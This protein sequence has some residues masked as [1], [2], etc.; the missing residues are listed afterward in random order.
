MAFTRPAAALEEPAQAAVAAMVGRETARSI[1]TARLN[2][3]KQAGTVAGRLGH[4]AESLRSANHGYGRTNADV[5]EAF[6]GVTRR[7]KLDGLK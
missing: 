4:I 1:R 3:E 5:R 7:S 2:W 6:A